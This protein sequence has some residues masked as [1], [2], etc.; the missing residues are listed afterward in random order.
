MPGISP[1]RLQLLR[2]GAEKPEAM[3]LSALRRIRLGTGS[4][5]RHGRLG[6]VLLRSGIRLPGKVERCEGEK[7]YVTSPVLA[8]P[9]TLS[10]HHIQGVRFADQPAEKDRG[11]SKYLVKPKEDKDLLY[12][13]TRDR[14]VQRTV[15]IEG[16]AD[17]CAR[18]LASAERRIRRGGSPGFRT[19][20]SLLPRIYCNASFAARFGV[21]IRILSAS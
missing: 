14:I 20:F 16:F 6:F 3:S 4:P 19:V 17:S 21:E 10:L 5:A 8:A 1:I 15:S 2:E 9:L 13:K 7:V 18:G 11:F 12:I